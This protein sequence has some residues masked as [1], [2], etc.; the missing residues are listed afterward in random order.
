M[1]AVDYF[2][3]LFSWI[4]AKQP[5]LSPQA[6]GCWFFYNMTRLQ[7]ELFWRNHLSW[8]PNLIFL[9][10]FALFLSYFYIFFFYWNFIRLGSSL[11]ILIIFIFQF[12]N[13]K[14]RRKRK[15]RLYALFWL[16]RHAFKQKTYFAR[17]FCEQ[18]L[19]SNF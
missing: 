11:F 13:R 9:N 5:I 6:I 19:S 16:K 1:G 15:E 10:T 18:F 4:L 3:F 2:L 8:V 17:R 12:I 7:S 14:R